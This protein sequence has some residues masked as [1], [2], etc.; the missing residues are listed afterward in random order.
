MYNVWHKKFWFYD[1]LKLVLKE[2]N[3]NVNFYVKIIVL[4]LRQTEMETVV[5]QT[6]FGFR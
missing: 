3:I 6:T 5:I 4:I 2:E 1:A